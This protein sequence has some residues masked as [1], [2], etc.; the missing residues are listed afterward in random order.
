MLHTAVMSRNIEM[1]KF[2]LA[3]GADIDA[4]DKSGRTALELA[5]ETDCKPVVDLLRKHQESI[6]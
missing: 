6:D 4:I 5:E 2:L 1:V 3:K